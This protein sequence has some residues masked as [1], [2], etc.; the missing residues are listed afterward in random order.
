MAILALTDPDKAIKAQALLD[1]TRV[2]S[3]VDL[4]V[5]RLH[6]S[7]RFVVEPLPINARIR[8][9]QGLLL[10][11]RNTES[12]EYSSSD[13]DDSNTITEVDGLEKIDSSKGVIRMD[14]KCE[15]A[16]S[17]RKELQLYGITEDFIY[18]EIT[19]YTKVLHQKTLAQLKT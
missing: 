9:Q 14:I 11:S 17:I 15:H 3:I 4:S 6:N 7:N 2:N 12:V 10:F 8:N 16:K 19:T 5:V 1:Q 13:F 18:P